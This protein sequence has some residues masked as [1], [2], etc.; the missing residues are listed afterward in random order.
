MEGHIVLLLLPHFAWLARC[1]GA[2]PSVPCVV[3]VGDVHLL[4]CVCVAKLVH[5]YMPGTVKYSKVRQSVIKWCACKYACI[6]A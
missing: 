1:L 5:T 6:R 2:Y 3:L 4:A